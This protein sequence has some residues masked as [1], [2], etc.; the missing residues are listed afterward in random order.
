GDRRRPVHAGRQGARQR[1]LQGQRLPGPGSPAPLHAWAE[2]TRF[3]PSAPSG[4]GGLGHDARPRAQGIAHGRAPGCR[5]GHGPEPRDP[6]ERPSALA[7]CDRG[8]GARWEE[9]DRHGEKGLM[10]DKEKDKKATPAAKKAAPV[11]AAAA[12]KATPAKAATKPAAAKAKAPAKRAVARP[13]TRVVRP[14]PQ[15]EER[16]AREE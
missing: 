15:R 11:K 14:E 7:S 16:R 3:G 6:A 9:R 8:R 12:T 4:L 5:Q 1:G 10:A 13:V 2:V